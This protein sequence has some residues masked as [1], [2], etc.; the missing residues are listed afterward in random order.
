MGLFYSYVFYVAALIV[1]TLIT[2]T[3]RTSGARIW[4]YVIL[5][6]N[7]VA[8]RLFLYYVDKELVHLYR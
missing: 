7:L 8:E 3:K 1:A 6:L 5:T 2:A 4:L